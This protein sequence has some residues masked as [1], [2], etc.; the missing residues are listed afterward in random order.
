[1]AASWPLLHLWDNHSQLCSI[2]KSH[3]EAAIAYSIP[4]CFKHGRLKWGGRDSETRSWI[5]EYS[6]FSFVQNQTLDQLQGLWPWVKRSP[7]AKTVALGTV[8]V[9]SPL[10]R[11]EYQDFGVQIRPYVMY[12]IIYH[13]SP[14]CCVADTLTRLLSWLPSLLFTETLYSSWGVCLPK[15][16]LHL[17]LDLFYAIYIQDWNDLIIWILQNP[18][19]NERKNSYFCVLGSSG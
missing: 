16:M 1:M 14:L 8:S 10:E 5:Q 18:M 4:E 6:P 13:G 12:L 9:F 3:S 15:K 2:L 11:S 17:S 7:F 19:I